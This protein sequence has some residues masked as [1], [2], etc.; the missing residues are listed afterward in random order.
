MHHNISSTFIYILV[1]FIYF[2]YFSVSFLNYNEF[3]RVYSGSGLFTTV[4]SVPDQAPVGESQNM[5]KE[6]KINGEEI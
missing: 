4:N 3:I 5:L 6:R 1:M 2:L